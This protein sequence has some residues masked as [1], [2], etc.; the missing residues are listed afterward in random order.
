M[1]KQLR[2]IEEDFG[3]TRK[4][5]AIH[6]NKIRSKKYRIINP[7]ESDDENVKELGVQK[8]LV[9]KPPL[10]A[11]HSNTTHPVGAPSLAA[12]FPTEPIQFARGLTP[13]HRP[14]GSLAGIIKGGII[15]R[16]SAGITITSNT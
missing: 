6:D 1:L 4:G 2:S 10:A 14:R 15:N 12:S 9:G 3:V 8:T 16:A 11:S 5:L 13:Y 7:N